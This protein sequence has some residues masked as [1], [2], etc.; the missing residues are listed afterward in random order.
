MPKHMADTTRREKHPKTYWK[1]KRNKLEFGPKF[2]T[3][4]AIVAHHHRQ[5]EGLV[6]KEIVTEADEQ[7]LQGEATSYMVAWNAH[8]DKR[9]K[10]THYGTKLVSYGRERIEVP[11]SALRTAPRKRMIKGV[12][13]E[14][15][16]YDTDYKME[17]PEY[18]QNIFTA[19]E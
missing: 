7:N 14:E 18:F 8:Q 11:T 6:S 12:L 5:I 4:S 10:K 17:L 9:K 13:A 15:T 19:R 16:K 2:K 3:E 1:P